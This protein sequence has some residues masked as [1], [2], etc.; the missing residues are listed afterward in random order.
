[1]LFEKSDLSQLMQKY[2]SLSK[3]ENSENHLTEQELITICRNY[4]KLKKTDEMIEAIEYSLRVFPDSFSLK[5]ALVTLALLTKN[6]RQ[7]LDIT[8][9]NKNKELKYLLLKLYVFAGIQNKLFL[10]D[11]QITFFQIV[12]TYSREQLM[13]HVHEI[14]LIAFILCKNKYGIDTAAQLLKHLMP[15]DDPTLLCLY[16]SVVLEKVDL[17]KAGVPI[18]INNKLTKL[19]PLEYT[20][21]A[22]KGLLEFDCHLLD[23]AIE[24]GLNV[25]ALNKKCLK[26]YLILCLS[27][28]LKNNLQKT[29]YYLKHG[30]KA[31]DYNYHKEIEELVGTISRVI[32]KYIVEGRLTPDYPAI[33]DF[34]QEFNFYSKNLKEED[35]LD[36]FAGCCIS[37]VQQHKKTAEKN[38]VEPTDKAIFEEGYSN[39]VKMSSLYLVSCYFSG[40]IRLDP[41]INNNL[42][43]DVPDPFQMTS[44]SNFLFLK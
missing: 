38:H 12:K 2:E 24:S 35:F 18:K 23:E 33:K 17:S 3:N 36:V 22:R 15:S 37:I 10:E 42:I 19:F 11:I 14:E 5:E 29:L 31:V 40:A 1:M 8:Q 34:L 44:T 27:Y 26:G 28:L 39:Y 9:Y 43:L 32:A 30:I 6:I 4:G 20:L 21:W 16:R 41:R 13:E 7:A 25:I